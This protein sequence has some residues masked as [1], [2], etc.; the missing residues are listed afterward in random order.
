MCSNHTV[1]QCNEKDRETL[2]TFK[3]GINDTLGRISTWSTENDCCAW[4][5][6]HCDNITGR[7]TE[8][9]LNNYLEGEMNLCILELEFLSYLDLSGNDFD[10]IRIPSIQHNITHSSNLVYLDLSFNSATVNNLHWLSPFSSLK[11][12]D[13]SGIDLHKE[14]NWLQAV[15][16][17]PSLLELQLSDCNLK[18]IPSVE[19]LNLS[20]LVTL[21]FSLNN[22]TSHLPDGF[23][24]LTKDI[25]YLNLHDRNMYGEIPSSLQNLQN[26]KHLDLYN[27]KLQGPIPDEIG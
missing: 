16:I 1:V 5:G 20:S 24:N 4:E 7:V 9:D 25:T 26:L 21:D 13:L 15:N 17:L 2:L 18:N 14:T 19:Y 27:N 12:L 6:V 23:F 11:Y 22:F 8:L 10:L 3:Q